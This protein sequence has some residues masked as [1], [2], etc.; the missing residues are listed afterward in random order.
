M[1]NPLTVKA[2]ENCSIIESVFV[3][4]IRSTDGKTAT[5]TLSGGENNVSFR[6]YG[7]DKLT[8]PYIEEYV[9]GKWVEYNISSIST[10]DA[11]G[12]GHCYDGYMVHYD[13]DGTY[14][15][16]FVTEMK[17]SS[18]RKFRVSAD[19]DFEG[20]PE[21]EETVKA[22]DPINVYLDPQELMQLAI[23]QT[24]IG[25]A[26]M[27]EDS[28]YVRFY[29]KAGVAEGYMSVFNASNPEYE[30]LT[31]TG[32]YFIFKY[33]MPEGISNNLNS[34]EFFTSTVNSGAVAGDNMVLPEVKQDNE[35]HII[36]IDISKRL[37]AF[38]PNAEGEYLA[39]YFRFDI[40]NGSVSA[41][42]Y[43]DFAYMGLSDSLDDIYKINSDAESLL[44]VSGSEY[45]SID[46]KTGETLDN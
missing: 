3:P 16:S 30:A 8:V 28:S 37:S 29:G 26:E 45:I 9:D 43:I 22:P 10:P 44:L 25:R 5:F 34:F 21:V 32:Q 7:F 33:R 20:W 35:W 23:G 4:K 6:V 38:K 46:P 2:E 13:G 27:A 15:Y 41:D 24:L 31:S 36:V 39:K 40:F 12:I 1:L 17:N 14:S 42:M 11:Y 19:K 18:A